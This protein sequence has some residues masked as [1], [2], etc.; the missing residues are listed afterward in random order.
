[1]KHLGL[2]MTIS[3]FP[4]IAAN[5]GLL[6]KLFL[7]VQLLFL[8]GCVSNTALIKSGKIYVGMAKSDLNSLNI[9]TNQF[10]HPFSIT[11]TRKFYRDH[12]LEII[13]PA[14]KS[15]F[16]V[17]ENVT[18]PSNPS[19]LSVHDGNGFLHSYYSSL[20]DAEL[21]VISIVQARNKSSSDVAV[22]E[23]IKTKPK[24]QNDSYASLR[25]GFSRLPL[26]NRSI[27]RNYLSD[28]G[29]Y[30]KSS[31][32]CGYTKAMG[33][34]LNQYRDAY[35]PELD[36]LNVADVVTLLNKVRSAGQGL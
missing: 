7:I 4:N 22:N 2:F 6:L 29:L 32:C 26:A 23:S 20:Y 18:I 1:M 13:A 36:L 15:M 21:R 24:L 11:A 30:T 35:H 8:S 31:P 17:F 5:N 10:Q 14:D 3:N 9:L 25:N 34:A 16:F 12:N 33:D 27:V 28:I 19:L